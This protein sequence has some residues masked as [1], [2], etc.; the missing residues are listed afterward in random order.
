MEAP[1][2]QCSTSS[3]GRDVSVSSGHDIKEGEWFG[4]V[5]AICRRFGIGA[6]PKFNGGVTIWSEVLAAIG[7]MPTARQ[8]EP[9]YDLGLVASEALPDDELLLAIAMAVHGCR[10]IIDDGTIV[11][12]TQSCKE[13]DEVRRSAR[14]GAFI[15]SSAAGSAPYELASAY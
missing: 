2:T 3:L 7:C 5:T 6:L 13:G 11:S 9:Q 14:Q 8:L 15:E 4:E 1:W 12:D 10:A